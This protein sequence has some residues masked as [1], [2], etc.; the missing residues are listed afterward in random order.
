L[1]HFFNPV[2]PCSRFNAE[3]IRALWERFGKQARFVAVVQIADDQDTAQ[4]RESLAAAARLFGADM[5]A[6]ID[7]QGKIAAACGVYSTPQ[8]VILAPGSASVVL[9]RGNYNVTRYCADPKTE[10]ARQALE[11]VLNHQPLPPESRS[12][13]I[14]YGCELPANLTAVK[15]LPAKPKL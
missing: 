15:H 7:D 2:C 1:L 5:E 14:A 12:A 11:A 4:R 10:F 13:M 9:F 8:A 3:H 6:V